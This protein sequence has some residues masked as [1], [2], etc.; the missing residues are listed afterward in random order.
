MNQNQMAVC[1]FALNTVYNYIGDES[2]DPFITK[3]GR[4]ALSSIPTT[5][6]LDTSDVVKY[7]A[8]KLDIDNVT[9]P[10]NSY[11]SLR[12][13]LTNTRN[14]LEEFVASN[15]MVAYYTREK[16]LYKNLA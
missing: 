11:Y 3:I 9:Q 2:N 1:A 14:A 4:A 15:N 12:D 13:V 10:E 16:D 8:K 5:L 7:A 6:M